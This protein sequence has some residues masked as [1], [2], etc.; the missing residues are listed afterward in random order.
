MIDGPTK[1]LDGMEAVIDR[2]FFSIEEIA[3]GHRYFQKRSC[4]A[5]S[6]NPPKSFDGAALVTAMYGGI[7]NSLAQRPDDRTPSSENWKLRS[8]KDHDMRRPSANNKS[9]EV[10]LERAIVEEWPNSWN[11]QMPIASGLFDEH[12]D[13][14][15]AVDLVFDHQDEHYDL[16]ELKV[17]MKAGSPLY[18]AMEILCYGLV[19]MA[20]RSD[21]AGNLKYNTTDLPVLRAN[22]ITLCVLAPESYFKGSQLMWLQC[23]INEG[24]E[25]LTPSGLKLDFCFKKFGGTWCDDLPQI[26]L[27][28]VLVLETVWQ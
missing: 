7:E 16:V 21:R 2:H 19:Y 3:R 13:K 26:H 23:A 25:R 9:V 22:S 12:S 17:N 15:R 28:D 5:F 18:A 14:R 6:K 11:Y 20:S 8:T 1:I 4:N 24:L 10:K 27:P